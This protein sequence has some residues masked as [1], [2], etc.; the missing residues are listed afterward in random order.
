MIEQLKKAIQQGSPITVYGY[1]TKTGQLSDITVRH[2]GGDGYYRLM[3]ASLQEL[4]Q[5]GPFEDKAEEE[6][7]CELIE[8]Y[9]GRLAAR[10]YNP[11][12]DMGLVDQDGVPT[13][14]EGVPVLLRLERLAHTVHEVGRESKSK[15]ATAEAKKR[16]EAHLPMGAY[17][18]RMNLEPGKYERIEF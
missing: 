11:P 15:S 16:L 9:S 17:V 12:R 4:M 10:D 7:R 13:T 1:R 5:S 3:E 8:S 18:F 14:A 2:V 6:A